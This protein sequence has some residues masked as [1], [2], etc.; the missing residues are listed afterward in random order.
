ME[1]ESK[2]LNVGQAVVFEDGDIKLHLNVTALRKA[3]E[4][5]EVRLATRH[6]VNKGGEAQESIKLLVSRLEPEYVNQYQTHSVR[7]DTFYRQKK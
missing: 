4:S 2:K 1:E 7:I 6:F 3:L 5:E